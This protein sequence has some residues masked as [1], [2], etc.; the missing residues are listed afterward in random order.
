MYHMELVSVMQL[1]VGNPKSSQ[2]EMFGPISV[3][4]I[5]LIPLL[6][7]SEMIDGTPIKLF[8]DFIRAKDLNNIMVIHDRKKGKMLLCEAYKL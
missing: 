7:H 1:Q 3:L 6:I 4:F 5:L 2:L 8:K